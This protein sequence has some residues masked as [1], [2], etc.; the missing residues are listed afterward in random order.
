MSRSRFVLRTYGRGKAEDDD[1]PWSKT[2]ARCDGAHEYNGSATIVYADKGYSSRASIRVRSFTFVS[3]SSC[4]ESHVFVFATFFLRFTILFVALSFVRSSPS[5][6]NIR[7]PTN[8]HFIF[9]RHNLHCDSYRAIIIQADTES[10]R[11]C[12][13][14]PFS[15]LF[16]NS[17]NY[18]SS[19]LI[20]NLNRY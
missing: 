6:P 17:L 12:M 4:S 7:F 16:F 13:H 11:F 18:D 3:L 8:L 10:S 15:F 20:L 9:F 19:D 14:S 5:S 1:G 2:D